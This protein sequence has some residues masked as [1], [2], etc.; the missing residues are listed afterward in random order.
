LLYTGPTYR[1]VR[2]LSR[3]TKPIRTTS[4]HRILL[5]RSCNEE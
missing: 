5:F 1:V 4:R 2:A 3:P